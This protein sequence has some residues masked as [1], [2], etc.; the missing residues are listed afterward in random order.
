MATIAINGRCRGEDDVPLTAL[1]QHLFLQF[2]ERDILS[3]EVV[4]M[5]GREAMHTVLQAK[6]DGVP[7]KF[8]V[9]VLKKDGCVYDLLLVAHP[10]H[11]ERSLDAFGH[12][13]RGFS[14]L[15]THDS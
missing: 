15:S 12:L 10:A 8:D 9:W 2:T 11:F 13:V 5:D 6:L 3:Q 14:T 7:K 1:T 4:P